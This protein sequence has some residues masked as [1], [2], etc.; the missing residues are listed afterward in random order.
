MIGN[1]RVPYY[2]S[3]ALWT[4]MNMVYA[5]SSKTIAAIMGKQL[6]EIPAEQMVKATHAIAIDKLKDADHR[7]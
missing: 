5:D 6:A 3:F 7:F 1:R 4:T 2:N